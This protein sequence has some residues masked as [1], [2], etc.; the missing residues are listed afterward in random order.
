MISGING[1]YSGVLN[2]VSCVKPCEGRLFPGCDMSSLRFLG[3]GF[4]KGQTNFTK[5]LN[6]LP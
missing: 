4:G 2:A 3:K 6:R 1:S 5:R